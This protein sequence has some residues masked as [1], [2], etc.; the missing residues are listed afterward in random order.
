MGEIEQMKQEAEQLKKQIAVTLATVTKLLSECL[1]FPLCPSSPPELQL[2]AEGFFPS[3]PLEP[4]VVLHSPWSANGD[5]H[6]GGGRGERRWDTT[7]VRS[8]WP[9]ALCLQGAKEK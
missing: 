3:T 1:P 4:T 8:K 2:R 9:P 6:S 5:L 7:P